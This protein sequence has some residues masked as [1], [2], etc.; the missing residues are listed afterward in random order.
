MLRR[1]YAK[2]CDLPDFEDPDLRA[3]IRDIAPRPEEEEL[4]RKN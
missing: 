1:Q 4:H 2:L 3:R